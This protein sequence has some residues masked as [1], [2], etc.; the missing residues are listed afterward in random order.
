SFWKRSLKTNLLLIFIT[1]VGLPALA[2]SLVFVTL[3]HIDLISPDYIETT[4][5][6]IGKSTMRSIDATISG[7]IMEMDAGDVLLAFGAEYRKESISDNPDDQYLRGEVFG[8]EATQANGSR[9]NKSI[10]AELAIPLHDTFELQFALRHER[11][12]DFG[13]TTDPKVSF[14]WNP[15]ED[16]SFRG[17]YGTAF[18]APSLH[19]LGLGKTDESPTLVDKARCALVGLGCE[20]FEFTAEF[21]G[22]PD[23]QPEE[24][25]SYNLGVIFNITEDLDFSVDYYNYKIENIIDSDTQ[26][27]LSNFGTDPSVVE[28]IPTGVAGD[29]GEVVRIFDTF[30]NIGN[31]D[32]SG[33]D[34]DV[35]YQLETGAGDFNFSYALNYIISYEDKRNDGNGGYRI[36]TVEGDFEQPEFRWRAGA[37]WKTDDFVSNLSLNYIGEFKQDESVRIQ[38]DGTVLRDVDSMITVDARVSY[39]GVE[40]TVLTLGATNLLDE[41]PPFIYNEFMGFSTNVHSGQGRYWYVNASYKF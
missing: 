32:T 13:N 26:F 35:N 31:L 19:Q 34:L 29:P 8:T 3:D 5:T 6:R 24:S 25:K 40:N 14:L 9:D 18:R 23:L 36:D 12:S 39:Y 21:E 33:I 22:N 11:Y 17:S 27:V 16:L 41:E 1:R 38:K 10:Y 15:M 37:D 30:Q 20:P 7:P 2:S 28:R 4:T